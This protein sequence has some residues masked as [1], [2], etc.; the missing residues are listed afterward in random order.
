MEEINK[1]IPSIIVHNKIPMP[2]SL[3]NIDLETNNYLI[4]AA[5]YALSNNTYVAIVSPKNNNYP[6][7]GK[8][9]L[10]KYGVIANV[11]Q[12]TK[13]T[14]NI[15]RVVLEVFEK[16]IIDDF[17]EENGIHFSDV[18][19]IY[20]TSIEKLRDSIYIDAMKAELKSKLDEY[21]KVM[22]IPH[23][24]VSIASNS[25]IDEMTSNVCSMIVDEK[26]QRQAM[27]EVTDFEQ[28][29]EKLIEYINK[30]ITISNIRKEIDGKVQTKVNKSQRE[31][32][33]RETL[34]TIREELGDSDPLNDYETYKAK[35]DKLEVTDNIKEKIYDDLSKLKSIPPM[36]Q[37]G[38][39]LKTYLDT[40]IDYPWNNST[41]D[42][43]DIANAKTILEEDH[44]GLEKV[45]ERIL[46][47]IAL[48]HFK[49]KGNSSIICLVGPPGTGKTSIANSIARVLEKKIVRISLGGVRD[50]SEI[51]G[52]RRTYIGAMPGRIIKGIIQSGVNNPL[53][54]F[55]E[56]DKI[57]S[58]FR[59]DP[60]SAL[61]E[62]LDYSQ[63]NTFRDN[64]L[65][66]PVDLT[67]VFFITTANSLAT[68]P[69]PLLDRMEVIEINSYT[70]NEKFH[71][72][73]EYLYKKKME[74]YGLNKNNIN[75]TDEAI[76]MIIDNYVREAGVRRLERKIAELL[77]KAAKYLLENTDKKSIKIT[78]KN[79]SDFLGKP[80]YNDDGANKKNAIGIVNGLAWT[81]VGGCTLQI[82]VNCMPGKGQLSLTGQMGD[83]MKESAFIAKSYIRS[84]GGKF[85]TP[86]NFFEKT[87]IHIHI[88]EGAVPKDGPSAGIT[89]ASAMISAIF[90]KPVKADVCM[91]GE[92]TLRGRVL[93]IGGL[94][95]KLLAA[96]NANLKVALVPYDN[97][98]DVE[99]IDKEITEGLD[100]VF[101]KNMKDVLKHI[102]EV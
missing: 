91:T 30:G 18:T 59:G 45:K 76:R 74:E 28:R 65:E 93:A 22:K 42:N 51:R 102:F 9:T 55:D 7:A 1:K 15:T 53:I 85:K 56:I 43:L 14:E 87:D 49:P 5:K 6:V 67:N 71:I 12:A 77:R 8:S 101:V 33:L 10:Y 79:L 29:Y 78:K 83:V 26:E 54:L 100:I 86:E 32:I 19:L 72:A 81:R 46:E 97:K 31:Y 2:K 35:I 99:E 90:E 63:N 40:V 13:V 92:I 82:E 96:K 38:G 3:V 73:K 57:G 24:Y 27:L 70:G 47:F 60:A 75:I 62:V 68:I 48:K 98:R 58:D 34:N 16:F 21:M 89:M 4:D 52:H 39:L 94:K 41:V 80:I 44:Y 17:Y 11:L 20:E 66:L 69:E 36:S 88:P 25:G 37:E 23:N 84:M 50:E 64:Y 61:L 95:E